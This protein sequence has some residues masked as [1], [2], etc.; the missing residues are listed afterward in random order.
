MTLILL[1]KL[2]HFENIKEDTVVPD[3]PNLNLSDEK[4]VKLS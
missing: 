1:G 2:I 4:E 3:I